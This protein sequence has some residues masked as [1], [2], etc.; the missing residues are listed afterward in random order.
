MSLTNI[1]PET[2]TIP[3]GLV[4]IYKENNLY[5][6]K[7]YRGEIGELDSEIYLKRLGIDPDS[8]SLPVL[9]YNYDLLNAIGTPVIEVDDKKSVIATSNKSY[10]DYVEHIINKKIDKPTFLTEIENLKSSINS[11]EGGNLPSGGSVGQVLTKT[12][13][14]YDW[15]DSQG[16][17]ALAPEING[18]I[19]VFGLTSSGSSTAKVEGQTLVL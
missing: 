8:S 17:S 19:L 1:N 18:E 14:G 11:I 6:Y 4:L 9:V 5:K 10:Y 7:S 13:D 3:S 2:Y 12:E 15:Q 16:G